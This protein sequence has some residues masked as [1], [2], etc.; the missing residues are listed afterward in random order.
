ML[1]FLFEIEMSETGID[2]RACPAAM[3]M[4]VRVKR[5]KTTLFLHC[6]PGETVLEL[7]QK[8]QVSTDSVERPGGV[9]VDQ[10]RLLTGPA[11]DSVLEDAKQLREL[12]IE[13]DAVL[14]L[15]FALAAGGGE[16]LDVEKPGVGTE[17]GAGS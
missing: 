10:Q 2:L 16:E 14:G 13:T 8:I 12:K 6:D 4:Y 7:K 17:S 5:H 1:N 3:S 11:F 15:V 9:P